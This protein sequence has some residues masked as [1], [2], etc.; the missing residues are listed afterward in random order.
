M[1]VGGGGL[2]TIYFAVGRVVGRLRGRGGG[3]GGRPARSASVLG[4]VW[5]KLRSA[6]VCSSA[7]ETRPPYARG[8]WREVL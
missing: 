3:A 7:I 6:M 4:R 2:E 1:V 5:R 8:E